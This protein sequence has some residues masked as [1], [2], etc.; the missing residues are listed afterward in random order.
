[1]LHTIFL[2]VALKDWDGQGGQSYLKIIGVKNSYLKVPPPHT[3][4]QEFLA[5]GIMNLGGAFF[6]S[7]PT[8]GALSRTV[9]QDAT[10][11][12]TQLVGLFSSGIVILVIL[13]LGFLFGPL[14]NAALAAI[15]VVALKG[16]Y[17]QVRD[18]YKYYRLSLADMVSHYNIIIVKFCYRICMINFDN[19]IWREILKGPIFMIIELS[20]N[21]HV[22]TVIQCVMG[23]IECFHED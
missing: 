3:H 12:Q 23:M 1:M 14:P 17:L 21:V 15:V 22:S 19:A 9:L 6:G 5:Y 16:L 7:F 8:A 2:C 11:G 4:S 13:F 10:G 18:I 20:Q